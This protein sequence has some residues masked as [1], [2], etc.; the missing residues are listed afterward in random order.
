MRIASPLGRMFN[1]VG[2][3]IGSSQTLT[4]GPI[5]DDGVKLLVLEMPPGL[6]KDGLELPPC[7]PGD[8]ISNGRA[9]DSGLVLIVSFRRPLR[10]RKQA[11]FDGD[12]QREN[13]FFWKS[14]CK[15]Y[16]PR[17]GKFCP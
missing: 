4:I 5:Y 12:S 2:I 9:L 17:R 3:Q 15:F 13:I 14:G 8:P 6:K 11:G 7:L 1:P 16:G 10:R